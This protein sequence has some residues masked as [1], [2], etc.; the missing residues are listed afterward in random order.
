MGVLEP[1]IGV[2]V[3]VP[4]CERICPYC[5]FAVVRARPLS[6][7]SEAAYVDALC[8]RSFARF[9]DLAKDLADD[10]F[11]GFVQHA[12]VPTISMES[13]LWH[14]LQT[15]ADL[16]TLRE[17]FDSLSGRKLTIVWTHSP[18]A[19]SPSVVN[20]LLHA[21]VRSGMQVRLAHPQGYE[22]DHAVLEEADQVGR[23]NLRYIVKHLCWIY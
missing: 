6:P 21:T 20:S 8:V 17:H 19:S 7:E 4:F 14:P 5:D 3:H 1:D 23:R 22:L 9:E 12:T 11:Q 2:Y 16:M 15:L 18:S 13:A 10:V